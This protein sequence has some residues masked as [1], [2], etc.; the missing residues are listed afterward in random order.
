M[1]IDSR[2]MMDTNS[3]R[4]AALIQTWFENQGLMK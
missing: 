4:V 1:C 3:D 2:L